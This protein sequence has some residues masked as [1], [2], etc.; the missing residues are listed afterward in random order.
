[1]NTPMTATHVFYSIAQKCIIDT[2]TD[3]NPPRTHIQGETLEEIRNRYPDAEY[4]EF[5]SAYTIIQNSHKRGVTETTKEEF[6]EML[7]VL[8]P[9]GWKTGDSCESF[10]MSE[11]WSGNI[12]DIYAR[13]GNRY[14]TIRDDI[15]TTH[16]AIITR[17]KKFMLLE[18]HVQNK[19]NNHYPGGSVDCNTCIQKSKGL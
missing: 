2:C 14:F 8:P 5:E 6:W 15:R 13:I 3:E 7:E 1:M 11:R 10:K 17:C 9:T 4:T 16:E 19:E 18:E 12:T